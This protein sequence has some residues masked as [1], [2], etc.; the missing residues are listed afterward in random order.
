MCRSASD[1]YLS[2]LLGGLSSTSSVDFDSVSSNWQRFQTFTSL[3]PLL[4]K[5]LFRLSVFLSFLGR[6]VSRCFSTSS[7]SFPGDPEEAVGYAS[8]CYRA[9]KILSVLYLH[10]LIVVIISGWR[11]F[12]RGHDIGEKSDSL[13]KFT[14]IKQ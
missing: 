13:K 1:R 2:S 12:L 10:G 3:N 7:R 9:G 6:R 8:E 14:V 11:L 5:V 4:T